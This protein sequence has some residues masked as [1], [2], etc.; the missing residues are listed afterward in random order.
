M[1]GFSELIEAD[2]FAVLSVEGSVNSR[3]SAGG[4][5]GVRVEEAL[6]KAEQFLGITT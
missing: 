5:A 6:E 4:T 1:Q 2:I 3:V